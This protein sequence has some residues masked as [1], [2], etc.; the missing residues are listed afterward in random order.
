M[1]AYNLEYRGVEEIAFVAYFNK[2]SSLPG[3][4]A[5]FLWSNFLAACLDLGQRLYESLLAFMNVA[6]LPEAGEKTV[7]RHIVTA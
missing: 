3:F 7:F 1:P 5:D 2:P 4:L 6:R